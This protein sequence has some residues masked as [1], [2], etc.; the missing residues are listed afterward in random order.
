MIGRV[1]CG[2]CAPQALGLWE[3]ATGV[4]DPREEFAGLCNSH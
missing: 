4:E 2:E 3:T 1:K